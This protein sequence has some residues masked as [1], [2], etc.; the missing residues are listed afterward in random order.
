MRK[1]ISTINDWARRLFLPLYREKFTQTLWNT[2]DLTKK[3]KGWRLK[4][5][6]W[7]PWFYSMR[8][9]GDSPQLFCD[10]CIAMNDLMS[11]SDDE[12]DVIIA[13]EMAGINSSGGV[14]V[15]SMLLNQTGRRIGYTRPL[16]VKRRTPDETVELLKKI[17]SE[18]ANY[19]QKSFVE[20]RLRNGDRVAIYDDMS[21]NLGS[22]IIARTIVLWQAGLDEISV[23]C[24]HIFY[25]LNRGAGNKQAGLDFINEKNQDL[26]PASLDVNYVIEFDEHLPSLEAVMLPEEFRVISDFQK[27]PKEFMD[28]DVRKE[29]LA[30]A[31]KSR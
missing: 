12:I 13:V 9:L 23:E 8:P 3:Q 17:G 5:G 18:V 20:A 11:L 22:K 27:N 31:A 7:A 10:C 28:K 24:D 29:V 19:G 6:Q 30:M 21:T 14:A 25:L 4:S 16:P 2:D 1:S 15:A 26:Y